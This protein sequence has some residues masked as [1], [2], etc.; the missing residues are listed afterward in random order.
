[1]GYNFNM[2][3]ERKE[4]KH[5][6]IGNLGSEILTFEY[7]E[8]KGKIYDVSYFDLPIIKEHLSK[9]NNLV[10]II[11]ELKNNDEKEIV[12][13]ET[14]D[15]GVDGIVNNK[16]LNK[17]WNNSKIH[18]LDIYILDHGYGK[19]DEGK[20]KYIENK[21]IKNPIQEGVE[22]IDLNDDDRTCCD[23]II[24]QIKDTL[25]YVLF[26]S[27][28]I[29]VEKESDEFVPNFGFENNTNFFEYYE[30]KSE[31]DNYHFRIGKEG[32]ELYLLKGSKLIKKS[33]NKDD[34]QEIKEERIYNALTEM[35]DG[36]LILTGNIASE[37][38]KFL[39]NL[40]K[41]Q[42]S[43]DSNYTEPKLIVK[44]PSNFLHKE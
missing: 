36:D 29:V 1:M 12:Y 34:E 31:A 23:E 15:Y 19:L 7:D 27:Y 28:E 41:G 17:I 13:L 6:N 14:T 25:D 35:F 21:I 33:F 9:S 18:D 24:N 40:A 22:S 42:N 32:D 44:E 16:T 8:Y 20:I 5:P 30:C 26:D 11:K 10:F 4:K 37:N 3:N 39:C 38:L 43:F 2:E